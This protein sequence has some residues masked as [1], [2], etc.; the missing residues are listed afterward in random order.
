MLDDPRTRA[1]LRAFFI[2]GCRC[3]TWRMCRRIGAVSRFHARD[4]R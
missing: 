2:T 4:H 3:A 1:K